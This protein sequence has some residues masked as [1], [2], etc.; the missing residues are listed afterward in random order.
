MYAGDLEISTS[1][2][3]FGLKIREYMQGHVSYI[4]Y[5]EFNNKMK[6]INI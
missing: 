2:V 4:L 1:S 6:L 5:Y 3:L